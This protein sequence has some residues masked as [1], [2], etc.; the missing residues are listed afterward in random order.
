MN[1][2]GASILSALEVVADERR[3]RAAAPGLAARVEALKGYQQERFRRS[4]ADLLAH[5][6][7]AGAAQFFLED[8]YGPGDFSRRDAQFARIVPALIR[9]FPHEIVATVDTLARLHALSERLDTEAARHLPDVQVDARHYVS[10]WQATGQPDARR[11]QIDLTLEVGR[12]LEHYTRNPLLRHSLRLM[13]GPAQA[14]GL[15]ELQHFLERGFDTFRTMRG[16]DEFLRTI[17]ERESQLCAR[18][19]DPHALD[20]LECRHGDD[21]LVQLP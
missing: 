18:L 2:L 20:A 21:A 10:A 14:A 3:A 12:A 16:A 5:P 4:Y 11:A 8:L 9:L 1:D 19:F 7:F 15:A 13:R 6:R 17:A